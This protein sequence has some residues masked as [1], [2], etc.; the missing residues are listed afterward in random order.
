ELI[1]EDAEFFD[2]VAEVEH[3]REILKRGTS[4]HRQIAVWKEARE[5][6]KEDTK[7]LQ[8]VVDML[9]KETAHGL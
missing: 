2:S 4:A 8:A 5:A 7:A 3:A 6:G 1:R 9:I